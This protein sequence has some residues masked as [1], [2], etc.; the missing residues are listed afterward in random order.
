MYVN[1]AKEISTFFTEFLWG[2]AKSGLILLTFALQIIMCIQWFETAIKIKQAK[3]TQFFFIYNNFTYAAL[4]SSSSHLYVIFLLNS[5]LI[6]FEGGC[7][8][9]WFTGKLKKIYCIKFSLIVMTDRYIYSFFLNNIQNSRFDI[10]ILLWL[11]IT[12]L[13]HSKHFKDIIQ[14]YYQRTLEQIYL[15]YIKKNYLKI[16]M[17]YSITKRR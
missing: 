12:S 6:L 8:D 4:L 3:M 11:L 13:F 16:S 9:W 2:C 5:V 17:S 1:V 7:G 10:I 14:C 15:F